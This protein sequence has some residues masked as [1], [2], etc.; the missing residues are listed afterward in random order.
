M[1]LFTKPLAYACLTAIYLALPGLAVCMLVHQKSVKQKQ[2]SFYRYLYNLL[3]QTTCILAILFSPAFSHI[4]K[5]TLVE[6]LVSLVFVYS[7]H[8]LATWL[9]AFLIHRYANRPRFVE[10]ADKKK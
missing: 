9:I 10:E 8:L 1:L 2:K 7:V 4:P 6:Q 3:Y 5:G